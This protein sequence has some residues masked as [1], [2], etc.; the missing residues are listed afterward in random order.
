[1]TPQLGL[2]VFFGGISFLG[3]MA[4]TLLTFRLRKL[5]RRLET[6]AAAGSSRDQ[7]ET[8]EGFTS[9]M[10][11][12][13]LQLRLLQGRQRHEI[14]E[15]YRYLRSL[16]E[17]EVPA[18]EIAGI[19]N[20][21]PGEVEQLLTLV[22]VGQRQPSA[23]ARTTRKKTARTRIKA[24]DSSGSAE[25]LKSEQGSDPQLPARGCR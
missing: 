3:L 19:L 1:M 8:G 9:S 22:K 17:R 12:A 24:K 15:R 20:L 4:S 23:A 10:R 14:P 6:P 11:Q 7:R 21:A 16:A 5:T 18:G 25:M 2:L 13:D